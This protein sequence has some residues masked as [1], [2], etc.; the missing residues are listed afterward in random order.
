MISN[1]LL[2]QRSW[3]FHRMRP[4]LHQSQL[5]CLFSSSS[6]STNDDNNQNSFP[7][8]NIR[9]ENPFDI[10]GVH[11]TATYQQV[12]R[13]FVEL[14]LEHHPD[15]AKGSDAKQQNQEYFVKFRQAF[16]ALRQGQDGSVVREEWGNDAC[17]WTSDEEFNAWFYEETGHS[18][19]MFQMDMTK[20]KQVID[21]VN[22]QAQ[23]G[24]DRG[25]MWEMAR[26]MA[27]QEEILK[28]QK[29]KFKK[30][31]VKIEG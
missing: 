2:R 16:E 31:D 10:L 1:F 13:R 29:Q 22:N 6:S 19:I 26:K 3:S 24:L 27:E 14:A 15:K 20:R 11:K 28:H 21:V 12:K 4:L 8:P 30:G 9:A 25:G 5:Q 23:G 18:D 7:H 17:T